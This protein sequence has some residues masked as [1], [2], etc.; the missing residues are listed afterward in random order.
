MSIEHAA[1]LLESAA[2][3]LR[4]CGPAFAGATS[5]A[6]VVSAR[7][8]TIELASTLT[9]FTRKAIESKIYRG[10]W[11]EGRLWVRRDGRILIDMRG[12]EAWASN[13]G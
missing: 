13:S 4:S 2:D 8:V 11:L 9:G 12:Y 5:S 10:D 1:R 7:F 6:P 3:E